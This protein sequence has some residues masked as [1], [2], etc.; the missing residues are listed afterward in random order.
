MMTVCALLPDGR[1]VG[2]Q[3]V[4]YR[5]LPHCTAISPSNTWASGG[6]KV[7]ISGE[8]L[9]LVDGIELCGNVHIG[10]SSS[11]RFE[12]CTPPNLESAPNGKL[13]GE[14]ILLCLA[15]EIR[16]CV[17]LTYL[18]NPEFTSFKA[19]PVGSDLRIVIAKK[20]DK[21]NLTGLELN[22][23]AKV[24]D[25][26]HQCEVESIIL[27]ND[28]AED[29]VTCRISNQSKGSIQSVRIEVGKFSKQLEEQNTNKYYWI[30]LGVFAFIALIITG[31]LLWVY[32]FKKKLSADMDKYLDT[33][34]CET[35]NEI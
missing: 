33:L 5:P 14:L 20:V 34:E 18:P 10:N 12:F 1:C 3:P 25:Q 21:L 22:I 15:N 17:Q 35:R 6:R 30:L 23:T 11:E 26:Q 29:S 9:D 28:M 13:Q 27:G 32:H 24:D 7:T 4:M 16:E 2:S 31:V 8:K 19:T